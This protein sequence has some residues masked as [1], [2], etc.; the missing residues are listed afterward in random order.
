[1]TLDVAAVRR[2]FPAL[3]GEW[4]YFDNAGGSQILG[5][6]IDAIVEFLRTSNVQLGGS[7]ALSRLAGERVAGGARALAR[8]MHCDSSEVV[9]GS[10]TTQLLA[11]LASS[12]AGQWSA[13][14]EIVVTNVDHEANVGCWRRLAAARGCVVKEW[15]VDPATLRLRLDDLL[16]LLGPR[17]R[18][19]AFTQASNL[20]GSAHP[21]AEI[22]RAVHAHG[23]RVCVDGVAHAPHRP[24]DVRAW[25][26]DYYVFSVYKVYGPHLAALYGRRERLLELA[27][28]NHFF[29]ADDDI[30][31]KLQP[32]H[33]T[34]ELVHALPA[35]V[36]Y[37]E[38]LDFDEVAA[39]ERALTARLLDFLTA[40]PGVRVLGETAAT[41]TRLPTVSFTVVGRDAAEVV[42]AVDPHRVGIKAGDFYARRLVDALG[43][44]PRG[45]VAR[46]SMV[47]YN[48]VD[49]VDR[50]IA[51]LGPALR[52]T[53]TPGG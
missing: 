32:G 34:Y 24:I 4:V 47:H 6:A 38:S 29:I 39:H 46:V 17:T 20:V 16:P 35:I 22:A 33:T 41:A 9:I 27:N 21:V 15:R 1:M 50:L 40:Q 2:Q 12:M 14:D 31:Y 48:T 42:R 30:P 8:W 5:A 36:A 53:P 37:L 11:N 18:L 19:V 26:V 3:A 28:L 52:P 44:G 25:D 13:G 10:S 23:A 7:Y 51:A 43:L 49:E 45:G